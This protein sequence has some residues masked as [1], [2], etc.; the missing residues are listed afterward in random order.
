MFVASVKAA[1]EVAVLALH[2]KSEDCGK[3]VHVR[4]GPPPSEELRK[5]VSF[6]C[7][8]WSVSVVKSSCSVLWFQHS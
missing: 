2:S 6:F 5:V 8:L 1:T 3:H 4:A 7:K